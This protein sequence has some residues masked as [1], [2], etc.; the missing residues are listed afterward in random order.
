MSEKK[1]ELRLV[2]II[3]KPHGIKGEV[4]FNIITDY[5]KTIIPGLVLILH[6]H[7]FKSLEIEDIRNPDFDIRKSAIV[8]FR[9]IN[10]RNLAETLRGAELYRKDSNLPENTEDHYWIDDLLECTVISSNGKILAKVLEVVQGKANDSLFVKRVFDGT[11]PAEISQEFLY[12]PLTEEYIKE[13]DIKKKKIVIN[14]LPEY[15]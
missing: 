14:K 7:D 1:S 6:H 3:G 4:I 8:K 2:G 11:E 15:I 5:P 12:I 13:I 10:N 9:E